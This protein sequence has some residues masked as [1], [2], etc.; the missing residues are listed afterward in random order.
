MNITSGQKKA[1]ILGA[2][3]IVGAAAFVYLDPLEMDLLGLNPPPAATKAAVAKPKPR[4]AAQVKKP[5]VKPEATEMMARQADVQPAPAETATS[6]ANVDKVMQ[7]MKVDAS[8]ASP[9]MGRSESP[10]VTPADQAKLKLPLKMSSSI[11]AA[12][13]KPMYPPPSVDLRHCLDE[14]TDNEIVKCAN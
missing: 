8:A 10:L 2:V 7:A 9:E 5:E 13:A 6:S 12:P 4:P 11:K 14:P 1:A 3:L